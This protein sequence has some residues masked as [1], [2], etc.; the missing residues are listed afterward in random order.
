MSPSSLVT[1][2]ASRR[3]LVVADSDSYV[4]WGAALASTLP[5]SWTSRLVVLQSPVMPSGR[6]LVDVL[7]GTRFTPADAE[8]RHLDHL[9]AVIDGFDPHAVLLS[10]RGP[11]VRVVAPRL[12]GRDD[13]PVLVSG[14]PGLTIPAVPKAVIYREQTDLVVLHSRREVREFRA[15]AAELAIDRRFGLATLP[16]LASG[17][18]DESRDGLPLGPV[19]ASDRTDLVFAAQAKVPREREDR[20]RV[21]EALAAHARRHPERRIVV[22]V[23]AR[24]GEAQTHYEEYDY[25]DL[26]GDLADGRPPP[27]LMVED[28]PMAEKL[29]RASALVTVSSTAALE[30]VALGL[31]VL[32]L[33]DFGVS[34]AMINT[35]FGGSGL[36]GS[37]D[38]LIEGRF[39]H[40]DAAWLADNYFHGRDA[41]DWVGRLHALVAARDIVPLP[42]LERRHDLVGGALR[43]AYERRR[44]LGSYDRS[45]LGVAAWAAGL[46]ARI[47]VRRLR[48]LRRWVAGERDPEFARAI[49]AM[50]VSAGAGAGVASSSPAR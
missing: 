29:A 38:E 47:V 30:A 32:L 6:Q 7:A 15:N 21:L 8:V 45:P 31:P 24:R 17:D 18:G 11:F 4:K 27:N 42:R 12:A 37:T 49:D 43:M 22:K 13:R 10:L 9:D 41:D 36:F 39:R 2:A 44:M 50:P 48:R 34:P 16:F 14:F 5:P 26:L 23:R 25:A 46:A 1:D 28:G 19:A 35:V 20:V 33:D 40:A 3:L